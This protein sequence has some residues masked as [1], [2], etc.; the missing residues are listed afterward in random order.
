MNPQRTASKAVRDGSGTIQLLC[1]SNVLKK[2][3]SLLNALDLGDFAEAR[4]PLIR[5]R[6]GEISVNAK[7]LRILTKALRPP[8]EKFPGLYYAD[9]EEFL[10]FCRD[11]LS[12]DV[13]ITDDSP[14]PDW[15]I[16]VHRGG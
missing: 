4:G 5:T 10:E 7:S 8:P 1:R 14:L 16:F 15:T 9:G 12:P 2:S 3:W 13:T 11:R 6:T